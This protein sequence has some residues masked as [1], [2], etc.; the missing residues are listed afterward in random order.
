V[1]LISAAL[2]VPVNVGDAL[3]TK[4]PVPVSSEISVAS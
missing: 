2:T 1:A 4:L 3:N